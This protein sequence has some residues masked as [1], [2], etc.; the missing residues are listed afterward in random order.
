LAGI[1]IGDSIGEGFRLIR[2][3]PALV[4]VWGAAQVVWS[5]AATE[6]MRP[7]YTGLQHS[8]AALQPGAAVQPEQAMAGLGP[9]LGFEGQ[10]MLLGLASGLVALIFSCAVYRAVLRPQASAFAYLRLGSAE[11]LLGAFWVGALVVLFLGLIVAMIP[12]VV[13]AAIASVAHAPLLTGLLVVVGYVGAIVVLVW[14]ILRL[15]FVGPMMVEDGK[16]H[17]TDA[18]RLTR[19]QA[20]ALFL[21]GLCMFVILLAVAAVHF[22]ISIATGTMQL[23]TLIQNLQPGHAAQIPPLFTPA[24]LI[25]HLISI[26][27]SGC[28]LAIVAAPWAKAYQG[29]AQPDV[30]ATFA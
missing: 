6:I 14:V 2:R 11:F 19:G 5:V 30:A 28:S 9:L 12:I 24:A 8:M 3:R 1:S 15:S 13:V 26:P 23:Q 16:F 10:M 4:L 17:L 20:G 18:W 29:L 27:F 25:G 21:V 22:A 7:T